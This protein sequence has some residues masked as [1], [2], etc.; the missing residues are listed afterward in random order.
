[1]SSVAPDSLADVDLVTFNEMESKDGTRRPC[2][3][4]RIS[5]V[6]IDNL[7]FLTLRSERTGSA[8]T[9]ITKRHY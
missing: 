1:M 6:V 4:W 8:K 9:S 7:E 3:D 5:N 2:P